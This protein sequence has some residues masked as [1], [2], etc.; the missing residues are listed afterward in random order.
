VSIEEDEQK[1]G[2]RKEEDERGRLH[3]VATYRK[4]T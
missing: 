3:D 1:R 2:I 4:A